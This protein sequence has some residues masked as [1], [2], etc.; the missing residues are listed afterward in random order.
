MQSSAPSPKFAP[1][2]SSSVA[3]NVPGEV[4]RRQ[5][6]HLNHANTAVDDLYSFASFSGMIVWRRL[7]SGSR[8]CCIEALEHAIQGGMV[9]S[10]ASPAKKDEYG[11]G[12]C[13]FLG[14]YQ[15][16]VPL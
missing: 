1:K 11:A 10:D 5:A 16:R 7:E 3:Q 15:K 4:L 9:W 13:H 14:M 8:G 12:R 2:V 6:A